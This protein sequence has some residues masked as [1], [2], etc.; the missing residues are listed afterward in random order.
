MNTNETGFIGCHC[1]TA[2]S[3]IRL[4]DSINKTKDLI[5]TAVEV[6]YKGIAITDHE[7]LSA[8]VE[9]LKIVKE[10]K[11]KGEMPQDFKL[12]L[13]NEIYLVDSLQDVRDN[14]QSGKTKFPHF[15][16]LACDKEG[17]RQLRELSSIAWGNSFF[18]GMMERVPTEKKVLAEIIGRNKG[19]LIATSACLGSELAINTLKMIEAEKLG[20]TKEKELYN[21]KIKDFV[22]WC[23]EVFG[24]DKFFI[25]LQPS[26]SIEQLEF[27]KRAV[28]IAEEYGLKC[29]VATDAHFLR[30]EDLKIHKAYLNSKDGD[31]ET[32]SFYSSCFVQTLDEINERMSYEDN[33]TKDVIQEAIKNTM[34]IGEMI[35]DYDLKQ[36]VSI[37]KI[38]LPSFEVRHLFK[39]AYEK[40]EYINKM[41]HS[42]E[43]QDRYLIK[44]I[45]DGF[46]EK[47]RYKNVL[48]R[49]T[50]HAFLQRID[51]ELEEL[52]CI[53]EE[54]KEA[55]SSYYITVRE[56]INIIWDDCGGNSLV[57]AGRGSAAGFL[58][59]YLLDITQVNPMEYNL[60]HWRHLHKSRPDFPDID[61]DTEGSKRQQ[62]LYALKKRFGDRRVLN[63]ATFGTEGSKS[64]ILTACR[65]LGIDNDIGMH[66]ASLIPFERGQNWSLSDCI[67]G[68][69]EKNREPVKEF[70]NEIDKYEGLKEVAMK[71]EGIE[72]KRS[73]HA[74][75][76]Y[77]FN[78]DYIEQ[79]AMMKAPNGQPTTQFSMNDSEYFG[80][81]KYDLL[82]IEALD[83][84]RETMNLLIE[85]DELKWEGSLKKTYNKYVHPDVLEYN[86]PKIWER[87]GKGEVL[88]L[89]QFN[90]QIGVETAKK[91]KPENLLET[92]VAN[93]LMRL[94]SDGGEIQPVDLYVKYKKDISLWYDEMRVYQ[95]NDEEVNILEHHLKQIYGVADTQEV[96]MLMVM[97]ERISNFSV[98]EANTLRKAIAKKSKKDLDKAKSLFYEKGKEI[99]TSV[100]LLNYVWE[101]QI[102]RQLGYSFST[103]HTLVY[104]VI[105]LQE[106]NLY[107]K[108]DPLYWNTACLTVNSASS[109]EEDRDEEDDHKKNKSTD[110]GKVAAAIGMMQ[111]FGVKVGLPDINKAQFGFKPDFE[112]NQIVFGLKGINGIGD[113]VVQN[114]IANRPYHSFDDFCEK[115]Y[116]SS[117]IK[118]SQMI[119]LIKAGCFDIYGGRIEIMKKFIGMIYSP[120]SK[121]NL[122][123]FNTLI[124]HSLIPEEYQIYIRFYKYRKYVTSKV[125]RIDKKDKLF[126]LDGKSHP[127]F[128]EH[129]TEN[130]IVDY[131]EGFPIIS[132]TK[133]KK[134]YDKKMDEIRGWLSL[135]ETLNKLNSKLFEEEWYSNAAG[136]IS[137][138]EMDSLSFYYHEHELA[139]VNKVVYGIA[140]FNQLPE[141]P[142]VVGHY[143][144]KN[145][146]RPKYE[147]VRLVGTVLDKDK[148]KHTVT[149]L[150]T[151]GVITIKYYD[152][153]F[154]HYNK[155]MSKVKPDGSKEILEK[156]WFTR[157][158]KLL[159]CGYRRGSQF[160]PYRYKDTKDFTH[161]TY[162]ITNVKEDGLLEM[163]TERK[164]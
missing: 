149:L 52:W 83:K 59:N 72:N 147:L 73:I 162:L 97:D 12:V 9:A 80:C 41:A 67:N 95:L 2:K 71:I 156:S 121:L 51:Q 56:I 58:I 123:N 120:K 101:V 113:E 42:I 109:E 93:S 100:N 44:L 108:Y 79:N 34:L 122:Q 126:L 22:L 94:M 92:S 119:Q 160:R 17:H 99:G 152:G 104:S 7:V 10:M 81:I 11:Q 90:T 124:Q 146:D 130:C 50:F 76:I 98:A 55:M 112:E 13:G 153:A 27:N 38:G 28:K 106:L 139:N 148:N 64:A 39:P 136:S 144:Y 66:I 30:P 134:E 125:H 29:I 49:E 141:S 48:S 21:S 74:G 46:D 78:N 14:Y 60:P 82:T 117:I 110:Y 91:V 85:H 127:F 118:K 4:V 15:I 107:H 37:P 142:K 18:T 3:N 154:A 102:K 158:N 75:G 33:L 16:L 159:L 63:I 129:F 77:I 143:K 47:V 1:H 62:I 53:T 128:I 132:D 155:Q 161:T 88:D 116:D 45:E 57:G 157:G 138:W 24:R 70:I 19:H 8:H 32:E 164:K 35:E 84:I 61:I 6:G 115:M 114:I 105:A 89:F 140:N 5:K 54:L 103:L 69:D 96:V 163:I 86:N 87:M 137:K 26:L 145:Q 133:F 131:Y 111:Q 20:N 65:G 135:D 150:T 31:R 25:E 68:N 36:P 43:E 40:Y 151:D 23:I